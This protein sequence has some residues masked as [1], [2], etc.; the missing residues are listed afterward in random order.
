MG[1]RVGQWGIRGSGGLGP[2]GRWRVGVKLQNII[3][4]LSRLTQLLNPTHTHSADAHSKR[5]IHSWATISSR[6]ALVA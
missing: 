1:V 5:T 4:Y 6:H 2:G 3:K